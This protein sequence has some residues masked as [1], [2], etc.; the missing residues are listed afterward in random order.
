M[1]KQKSLYEYRSLFWDKITQVESVIEQMLEGLFGYHSKGFIHRDVKLQNIVIDK[2]L[3]RICFIDFGTSTTFVA[4]K[5]DIAYWDAEKPVMGYEGTKAFMAPEINNCAGYGP[6]I[7]VFSCGIC[8]LQ[9]LAAAVGKF[10]AFHSKKV[11]TKE[12]ITAF[13]EEHNISHYAEFVMRLIENE[14]KGRFSAREE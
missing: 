8:C 1:P 7:D 14:P 5:D 2:E 10:T 13:F 9:L 4:I 3:K 6:K 11:V 12:T